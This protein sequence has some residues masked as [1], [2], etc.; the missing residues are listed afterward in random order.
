M[1]HIPTR[2]SPQN[3]HG[4]ASNVLFGPNPECTPAPH[5]IPALIRTK[6]GPGTSTDCSATCA[7]HYIGARTRAAPRPL[8]VHV[9]NLPLPPSIEGRVKELTKSCALSPHGPALPVHR[10]SRAA[11][12]LASLAVDASSHEAWRL[13]GCCKTVEASASNSAHWFQPRALACQPRRTPWQE[14]MLR[15]SSMSGRKRP[16]CGQGAAHSGPSRRPGCSGSH[17]A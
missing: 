6:H 12:A 4:T 8:N 10:D 9:R 7:V 2:N 3:A 15:R 5:P 11:P 16:T 14:L 13:H 17:G 1:Q